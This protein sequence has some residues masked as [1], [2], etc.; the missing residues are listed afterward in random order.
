MSAKPGM[1][2]DEYRR[3]L[4]QCERCQGVGFT[5][6]AAFVAGLG[7][8]LG[9]LVGKPVRPWACTGCG[10]RGTLAADWE[11]ADA[12]WLRLHPDGG[13]QAERMAWKAGYV[14]AYN[15]RARIPAPPRPW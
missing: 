10:G 6:W 9:A 11:A 4:W 14:Q 2:L 12:A 3:W 15:D 13:G 7:N 5:R 1:G 8:L